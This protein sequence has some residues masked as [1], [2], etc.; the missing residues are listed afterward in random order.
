MLALADGRILVYGGYCKE[1]VKKNVE[2]GTTFSDMYLLTPD[3]ESD[4][5]VPPGTLEVVF[6]G[7][8]RWATLG[9]PTLQCP[10]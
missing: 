3:S 10:M 4:W 6:G 8:G 9:S 2:R 7:G 1:K 5:S